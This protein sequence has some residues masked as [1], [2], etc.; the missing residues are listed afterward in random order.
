[1]SPQAVRAAQQ[2]FGRG[3][4]G[5]FRH[6]TSRDRLARVSGSNTSQHYQ[7]TGRSNQTRLSGGSRLRSIRA[8]LLGSTQNIEIDSRSQPLPHPIPQHQATQTCF[9]I[10]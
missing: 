1:V 9:C 4:G 7:T 6:G 8:G 2:F 10:R 5:S 3:R